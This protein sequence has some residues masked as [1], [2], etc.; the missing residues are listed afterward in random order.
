MKR[1]M[2][3]S[4]TSILDLFAKYSDRRG[5]T[6][7]P[8][9]YKKPYGLRIAKKK[10]HPKE[11]RRAEKLRR[12]TPLIRPFAPQFLTHG[13]EDLPD[14]ATP[15]PG[16]GTLPTADVPVAP[17]GVGS[18][19]PPEPPVTFDISEMVNDLIDPT[20][21]AQTPPANGFLNTPPSP[22]PPAP[23][24]PPAPTVPLGPSSTPPPSH[25]P[26][27]TS[28]PIPPPRKKKKSPRQEAMDKLYFGGLEPGEGEKLMDEFGIN[29][30]DV[31]VYE[32]GQGKRR[33]FKEP[34]TK[35]EAIGQILRGGLPPGK[36]REWAMKFFITGMD[37][38]DHISTAPPLQPFKSPTTAEE[39]LA[40]I[41]RQ[42]L[43]PGMTKK[44]AQKFQLTDEDLLDYAATYAT[45]VRDDDG[46]DDGDDKK[47]K[48]KAPPKK[49]PK[50]QPSKRSPPPPPPP[51]PPGGGG[52]G[53]SPGWSPGSSPGGSS[54]SGGSGRRPN[55]FNQEE[56]RRQLDLL[57]EDQ[58][59]RAIGRRISGITHTNTITT[60]YKD[61]GKPT[62][63]RTSSRISNP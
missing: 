50:K 45:R 10:I 48:K 61:T 29:P 38:F 32:A 59:Q 1:R 47:K 16:V 9:R 54:S 26:P 11:R 18:P 17:V 51:P 12:Q 15:P 24:A 4:G 58:R 22:I 23:T 3:E 37:L 42:G 8:R 49:P 34:T 53:D 6:R 40:L 13:I 41:L 35:L 39:A 55:R 5:T 36:A 20:I 56:L 46:G 27:K 19:L 44:W 52:G 43:P 2:A 63:Q 14:M 7:G 28:T 31:F 25:Q 30:L 62:V 60:V 33:Q 57:A 21:P